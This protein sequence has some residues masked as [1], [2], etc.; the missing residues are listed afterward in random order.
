LVRERAN[1]NVLPFARWASSA[2]LTACRTRA[3]QSG[4]RD[5]SLKMSREKKATGTGLLFFSYGRGL[6]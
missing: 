6:G 2:V 1:E 5:P 4:F 3:H